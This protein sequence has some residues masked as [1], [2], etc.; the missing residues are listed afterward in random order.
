V[1][2]T[3][4]SSHAGILFVD[5]ITL[6]GFSGVFDNPN[7]DEIAALPYSYQITK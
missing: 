1:T 3:V 5:D 6:A 4:G 2:G 7:G